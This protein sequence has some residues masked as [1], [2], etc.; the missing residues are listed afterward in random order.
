MRPWRWRL[1]L[2]REEVEKRLDAVK[3]AV[4][5]VAEKEV[6]AMGHVAANL[7]GGGG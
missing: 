5:K 7:R 3:A 6:A 1:Y 4:D 2:E